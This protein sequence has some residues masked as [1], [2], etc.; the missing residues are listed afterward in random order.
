MTIDDISTA[1][2]IKLNEYITVHGSSTQ[3]SDAV[4]TALTDEL[5]GILET[6]NPT[7]DYPP[8]KK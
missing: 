4:N 2:Q 5:A 6:V 1:L 3:L 8:T 7:N